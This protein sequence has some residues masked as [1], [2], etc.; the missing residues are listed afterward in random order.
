MKIT[1]EFKVGD[2]AFFNNAN[3]HHSKIVDLIR[4]IS[5]EKTILIHQKSPMIFREDILTEKYFKN[6]NYEY[7]L[8]KEIDFDGSDNSKAYIYKLND[9]KFGVYF[10]AYIENIE[11]YEGFYIMKEQVDTEKL[12]QLHAIVLNTVHFIK[13]DEH[14]E[15]FSI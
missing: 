3:E 14:K 15:N 6:L 8:E 4:D 10:R 9:N 7:N 2:I 5:L 13:K 11:I 1:Y 12:N